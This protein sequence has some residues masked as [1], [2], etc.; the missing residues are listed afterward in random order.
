MSKKAISTRK[1]YSPTASYSQGVLVNGNRLYVQG[2]IAV[3]PGVDWEKLKGMELRVTGT[4][5]EQ[6]EVVHGDSCESDNDLE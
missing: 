5:A 1:A 3:P 6:V 2:V 4:L